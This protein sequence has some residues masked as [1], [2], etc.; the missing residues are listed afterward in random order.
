MT[1]PGERESRRGPATP[2]STAARIA[3]SPVSCPIGDA[4]A[5]QSLMPLYRAGLWLAVNM[6]PG[7]SSMPEAK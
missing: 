1:V 6:A 5:R 4:P 3:A 2:P 7:A